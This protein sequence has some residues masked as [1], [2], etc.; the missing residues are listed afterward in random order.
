MSKTRSGQ[1]NIPVNIY[2]GVIIFL[3]WIILSFFLYI[4]SIS[5]SAVDSYEVTFFLKDSPLC[6]ILVLVA[7][8]AITVIWNKISFLKNITDALE[9]N[10]NLFKALKV[11]LLFAIFALSALFVTA[12]DLSPVSDQK[13][14]QEAVE[15][16]SKGD[17]SSLLPGGYIHTYPNQLGLLWLSS[18][19]FGIFGY[20]NF[21]AFQ[22]MNALCLSWFYKRLSDITGILCSGGKIPQILVL[23][24]GV[25]FYP[26]QIYCT[27]V[28]GTIPGLALAIVSFYH[29][30]LFY[31]DNKKLHCIIS[32][33]AICISMQ[34]KQ[35]FLIFF[36]AL[37]LHSIISALRHKKRILW[38]LPLLLV[39]AYPVQ[40]RLPAAITRSVTGITPAAGASSYSWIAMGLQD[41]DLA[42]GWYNGYNVNTYEEC[43]YDSDL[44]SKMAIDEIKSRISYFV[45]SPYDAVN[46][47]T[48]KL[49]SQWNDPTYEAYW[50]LRTADESK[51]PSWLLSFTGF[52][53]FFAGMGFLSHLQFLILC[54]AL[55]FIVLYEKNDDGNSLLLAITVVGG[56]FFHI[57]WEGKSQYTL[58]YFILLFPLAVLGYKTLIKKVSAIIKGKSTLSRPKLILSII[59]LILLS[60]LY[61]GTIGKNL[62]TDTDAYTST[63][64]RELGKDS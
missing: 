3:F 12:S 20:G 56:F 55:L 29:A 14:V 10:D 52:S 5:I 61:S 50:I 62:T 42:E 53:A 47:F 45:K 13:F 37:F 26:L 30:L 9:K 41:S 54:G 35:N 57:F 8:L 18:I 59:P 34:F 40:A 15:G 28:Y 48:R 27:F 23:I 51:L 4:S 60:L 49:S 7:F 25:L 36:I 32:I 21:L 1:K 64:E 2:D 63:M 22:I 19:F 17:Y 16:F 33:I 39:I 38:L 6:H 44:Q 58:P 24:L 43:G 46:F 31:K 11:I